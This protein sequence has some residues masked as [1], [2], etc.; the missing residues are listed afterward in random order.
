MIWVQYQYCRLLSFEE[1]NM[2]CLK[3]L[4]ISAFHLQIS[5]QFCQRNVRSFLILNQSVAL[6]KNQTLTTESALVIN[7]PFSDGKCWYLEGVLAKLHGR[8]SWCRVK[9]VQICINVCKQ[10][11]FWNNSSYKPCEWASRILCINVS[12]MWWYF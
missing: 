6:E 2:L 11:L 4:Y 1:P 9:P 3:N 8:A 5:P 7:F 12:G 10:D